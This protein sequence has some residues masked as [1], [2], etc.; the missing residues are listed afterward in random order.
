MACGGVHN[1]CLT[2]SEIPFVHELYK[3]F[4]NELFV[5]IEL[6]LENTSSI[7]NTTNNKSNDIPNI[8]IIK[9][10]K[11]VLITRSKYFYNAC[12]K[13][14]QSKFV[15][16]NIDEAIF[17]NIIDYM[18]IDD[19]G[20]IDEFKST[21]FILDALKLAKMLGLKAVGEKLG[22]KLKSVL[23]KYSEAL[24]IVDKAEGL[25]SINNKN[26]SYSFI[27]QISNDINNNIFINTSLV[28]N[29]NNINNSNSAKSDSNNNSNC[30]N[31][32]NNNNNVS[33]SE[34]LSRDFKGLFF[35]PNGTPMLIFDE[36][37]ID[38]IM[39][40]CMLLNLND[41]NSSKEYNNYRLYSQ[42]NSQQQNNNYNNH[43]SISCSKNIKNKSTTNTTSSITNTLNN[44][45]QITHSNA[46][47]ISINNFKNAKSSNSFNNN[48]DSSIL[49]DSSIV[50][51]KKSR[52]IIIFN[53]YK[54]G[55]SLKDLL[56]TY[57]LI[58]SE[59]NEL[60][61]FLNYFND[62]DSSDITI[63]V[64]DYEF[65]CHKVRYLFIII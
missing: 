34:V 49:I 39:G 59:I 18:Y 42:K 60:P 19:L 38:K 23:V 64:E 31:T 27:P 12:I 65:Y 16:K 62:K 30:S 17:R 24:Q 6:I 36:N 55:M 33:V 63:K 28:N 52:N 5:D 58:N 61:E 43:E 47:S 29:D 51:D 10:H 11:F 7:N 32:N 44:S 50:S 13:D 53:D 2:Q 56:K 15:F 41:L 54:K 48:K 21:N 4:K 26:G 46:M 37:L 22:F 25:N 40:N 20:F 45:S 9:A 3:M 35:L 14:K 8:T 57:S 1:I